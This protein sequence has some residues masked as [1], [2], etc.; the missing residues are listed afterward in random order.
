MR[1]PNI[2]ETEREAAQWDVLCEYKRMR[3]AFTPPRA[4]NEVRSGWAHQIGLS[5][6]DGSSH[7]VRYSYARW[8]AANRYY[9][10]IGSWI[11]PDVA[12]ING[13]WTA[14][15]SHWLIGEVP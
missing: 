2:S 11:H 14:H 8:A 5:M 10:R 7:G 9:E 6:A 15:G 3:R 12:R 1:K 4:M 13:Q